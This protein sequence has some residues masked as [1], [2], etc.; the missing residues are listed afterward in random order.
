MARLKSSV[1]DQQ[2]Q[3]RTHAAV[4]QIAA[5][6]SRVWCRR[7]AS[8][9]ECRNARDS[10]SSRFRLSFCPRV[11]RPRSRRTVLR[12][13]VR[14]RTSLGLQL[15]LHTVLAFAGVSLY[16]TRR[17]L[18]LS[19]AADRLDA[20][21]VSLKPG[22]KLRVHLPRG[23]FRQRLG[24]SAKLFVTNWTPV[25]RGESIRPRARNHQVFRRHT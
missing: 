20:S 22:R 7:D 17:F 23:G 14:V 25:I 15:Y 19:G 10:N 6:R 11:A 4:L 1:S 3:L 8:L 2:S 13:G 21:A 16:R 12:T 24:Y 18:S 5:S 9:R